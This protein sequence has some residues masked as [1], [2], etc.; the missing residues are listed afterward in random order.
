MCSKAQLLVE[1]LI[2]AAFILFLV[3]FTKSLLDAVNEMIKHL[4]AM[5][6]FC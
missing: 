1:L 6:N 5:F 4:P 2:G 3:W